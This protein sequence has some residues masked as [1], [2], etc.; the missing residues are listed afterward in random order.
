TSAQARPE[1]T[2]EFLAQVPLFA[3]LP[4][5]LHDALAQRARPI[6]VAADEWLFRAGDP[7]QDMYIVRAGRLEVVD[8]VAGAVIRE[9]GRGDG[10]G[11]LAL[12]TGEPRSASVRAARATDL[13]AVGRN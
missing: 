3:G 1:S 13:V 7:A 5:T 10:L 12:L 4:E 2:A 8:D 6:S 9:L 11:E